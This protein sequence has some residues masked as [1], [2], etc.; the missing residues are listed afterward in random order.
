MIILD[1]KMDFYCFRLLFHL[2]NSFLIDY[3]RIMESKGA[4]LGFLHLKTRTEVKNMVSF[5]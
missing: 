1:H 4:K 2:D 5:F 3:V